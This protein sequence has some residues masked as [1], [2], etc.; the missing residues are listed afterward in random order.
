MTWKFRFLNKH[1]LLYISTCSVSNGNVRWWWPVQIKH[2][3]VN[4]VGPQRLSNTSVYLWYNSLRVI[5][6]CT[7]HTPPSMTWPWTLLWFSGVKV[8]IIKDFWVNLS[9]MR[10]KTN[11][12][13][14]DRV[15][16]KYSQK[17]VTESTLLLK[18][19][20][21]SILVESQ[22]GCRELDSIG[23]GSLHHWVMIVL[24]ASVCM[25]QAKTYCLSGMGKSI[26]SHL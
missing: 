13:S 26:L 23:M 11:I 16:Y 12:M 15:K 5:R 10:G 1:F 8:K 24:K 7:N 18:T 17:K 4:K 6:S 9:E 14:F 3:K 25:V 22:E 20:F 2:S 21:I 19:I